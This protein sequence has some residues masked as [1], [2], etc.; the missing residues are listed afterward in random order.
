[1]FPSSWLCILPVIGR[2]PLGV[3]IGSGATLDCFRSNGE[4]SVGSPWLSGMAEAP[5]FSGGRYERAN[6]KWH[7]SNGILSLS[8]DLV[9]QR[10]LQVR[11]Q[12]ESVESSHHAFYSLAVMDTCSP[13]V[14]VSCGNVAALLH[15][16][17][18]DRK[19]LYARSV[20]QLE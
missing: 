15:C 1:M 14:L 20:F 16:L 18:D 8:R 12:R 10:D 17:H 9:I 19:E 3:S 5:R 13:T 4:T 7:G 2:A 11:T 6:V